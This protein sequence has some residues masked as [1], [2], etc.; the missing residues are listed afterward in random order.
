MRVY[1]SRCAEDTP[2]YTQAWEAGSHHSVQRLRVRSVL[3]SQMRPDTPV[4]TARVRSHHNAPPNPNTMHLQL[5]FAAG[6][7]VCDCVAFPPHEQHVPTMGSRTCLRPCAHAELQ[8]PASRS[9]HAHARGPGNDASRTVFGVP[10]L[11][12]LCMRAVR[13]RVGP[14]QWGWRR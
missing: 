12:A 1:V 5:L 14:T 2:L 4:C 10:G 11:N 3:Q 13:Q 7:Q 6:R 8:A 9:P